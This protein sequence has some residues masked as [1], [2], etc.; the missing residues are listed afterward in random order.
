MENKQPPPQD[1]DYVSMKDVVELMRQNNESIKAIHEMYREKFH[2]P[3]MASRLIE[4]VKKMRTYSS[5]ILNRK[6][7]QLNE[8]QDQNLTENVVTGIEEKN[9]GG[10]F[11]KFKNIIA[12]A[13]VNTNLYGFKKE[14]KTSWENLGEKIEIEVKML[15]EVSPKYYRSILD[16]FSKMAERVDAVVSI[17]KTNKNVVTEGLQNIKENFSLI[18]NKIAIKNLQKNF[19][20]I[21]NTLGFEAYELHHDASKDMFLT[22]SQIQEKVDIELKTLK[23]ENVNGVYVNEFLNNLNDDSKASIIYSALWPS[24]AEKI[25][26]GMTLITEISNFEKTNKYLHI[27]TDFAKKNKMTSEDVTNILQI[28]PNAFDDKHL[29]AGKVGADKMKKNFK[30][31]METIH[32]FTALTNNGAVFVASFIKATE[33]MK[34]VIKGLDIEPKRKE[35]LVLSIDESQVFKGKDDKIYKY[36]T[37]RTNMM[38]LLDEKSTLEISKPSS[39]IKRNNEVEDNIITTTMKPI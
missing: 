20:D 6:E 3:S 39:E 24:L 14:G 13:L 23:F 25:H 34:E 27:I 16:S 22:E 17:V 4:N 5:N 37:I 10:Y 21:L 26:G 33:D 8:N 18:G 2:K 7:P 30:E 1:N 12:T 9:N 38:N 31:I 36:K 29:L 35:E 32:K 19:T 15:K 28:D 11:S